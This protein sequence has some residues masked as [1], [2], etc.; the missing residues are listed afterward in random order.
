MTRF[1]HIFTDQ[2]EP[3]PIFD[4]KDTIFYSNLQI[5][6]EIILA[7][8]WDITRGQA[9]CDMPSRVKA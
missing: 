9:R 7:R 1:F 3:D 5:F 4:C 8:K 2:K 6:G